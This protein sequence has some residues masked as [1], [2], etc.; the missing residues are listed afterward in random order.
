MIPLLA[1]LLVAAVVIWREQVNKTL[2]TVQGSLSVNLISLQ[3]CVADLVRQTINRVSPEETPEAP[4]VVYSVKVD[5]PPYMLGEE[6]GVVYDN[7]WNTL[8]DECG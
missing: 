5:V 6:G 4:P 3:S 8:V 7:A 2:L 1:V